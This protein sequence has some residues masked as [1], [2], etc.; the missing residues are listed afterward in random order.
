MDEKFTPYL[1]H[2]GLKFDLKEIHSLTN[3]DDITRLGED[4]MF[5]NGMMV[6][7]QKLGLSSPLFYD[8]IKSIVSSSLLPAMESY[9]KNS[10]K[11]K[12]QVFSKSNIS[13]RK[14]SETY[15]L[16]LEK[17]FIFQPEKRRESP[18]KRVLK[19]EVHQLKKSKKYLLENIAEV[20]KKKEEE[21]DDMQKSLDL[22]EMELSRLEEEN[23]RITANMAVLEEERNSLNYKIKGIK[24]GIVRRRES[25]T[26]KVD[27]KTAV[28]TTSKSVVTPMKG[29]MDKDVIIF[30]K[31]LG[32]QIYLGR[33]FFGSQSKHK[34]SSD[35]WSHFYAEFAE[36]KNACSQ[37]SQIDVQKRAKFIDNLSTKIS[38]PA[39]IPSDDE[40]QI[41][42]TELIRL[43]KE[44]FHKSLKDAG[45]SL[46]EVLTPT[47][48]INIQSLLRLPTNKIRNLRVC[49]SNLNLK[50]EK[51]PVVSHVNVTTV[52]SSFIGLRQKKNDDNV[53]PSPF[54]RVKDL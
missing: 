15:P 20:V 43:N 47:Q 26:K 35:G 19:E 4:V 41:L 24:S 39:L 7:L 46:M 30:D 3:F 31:N 27:D 37:I 23:E 50:K 12:I 28:T 21:V 5:T 11:S 14:T 10:F 49:L 36:H 17:E 16:F 29:I 33:R 22:E 54:I 38:S 32:P 34:K 44:T 8:L 18:R 6:E 13:A 42:Y 25:C 1:F 52:E 48:A 51:E 2:A 45:F 40:K 53:T 9:N